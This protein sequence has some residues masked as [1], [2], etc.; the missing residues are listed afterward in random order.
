VVES[1]LSEQRSIWEGRADRLERFV[2]TNND[3][4][5]TE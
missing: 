5:A 4:D 1:W 3:K 2:T